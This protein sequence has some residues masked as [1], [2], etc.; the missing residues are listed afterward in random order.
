[1]GGIEMKKIFLLFGISAALISCS[2][3]SGQADELSVTNPSSCILSVEVEGYGTS[4]LWTQNDMFGIYGSEKGTNIRYIVES[5]NF[6]SDG[7]TRIYGV[8]AE[9]N[10]IGYYPYRESGY[11]A[12]A[13]GRQPLPCTQVFTDSPEKQLKSNS[14]L[15]AEAQDGKLSFTYECGILHLHMTTDIEGTV[16]SVSLTSMNALCG[17]LQVIGE[18]AIIH[19]PSN[20]IGISGIN[21][22]CT[23]ETPL[24]LYF[25]LAPGTY[26]DLFITLNSDMESVVK[27]VET[28]LIIEAKTV[29]KCTISNKETIYEGS[30]IIITE[31]TFDD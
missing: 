22:P 8:G 3:N 11:D 18:E 6:G 21:L 14:I 7:Q 31:G 27:P 13:L 23:Q 16:S 17:D 28:T 25:M 4:H 20:E 2:K 1:M 12:V 30:D 19:N 24:D 10:I 26:S 5:V 9:G 15:V 29:A